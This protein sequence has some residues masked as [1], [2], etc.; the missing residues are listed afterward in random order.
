VLCAQLPS[1]SSLLLGP[2]LT[3]NAPIAP[4]DGQASMASHAREFS[5]IPPATRW[6]MMASFPTTLVRCALSSDPLRHLR[7]S[8]ETNSFNAWLSQHTWSRVHRTTEPQHQHSN[9]P[10]AALPALVTATR[11]MSV[12]RLT[13]CLSHNTT[14]HQGLRVGADVVYTNGW[15]R[16]NVGPFVGHICR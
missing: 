7:S 12:I 4:L 8:S 3:H 1:L 10:S 2:W 11:T 15:V 13:D 16:P 6:L 9:T 14:N 5:F